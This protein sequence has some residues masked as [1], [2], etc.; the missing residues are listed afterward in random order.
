MRMLWNF[1]AWLNSPNKIDVSM[2]VTFIV[3]VANT[4]I[5]VCSNGRSRFQ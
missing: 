1:D 3:S 4:T 2:L 5:H